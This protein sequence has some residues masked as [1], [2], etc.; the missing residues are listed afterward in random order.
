VTT[1]Y[2][3]ARLAGVSPSTV[4]RALNGHPR[5]SAAT[6]GRIRALADDFGY[7]TRATSHELL[8]AGNNLLGCVMHQNLGPGALEILQGMMD[9]AFHEGLVL[10]ILRTPNEPPAFIHQAVRTLIDLRIRAI[11]VAH[12]AAHALPDELLLRVRSSGTHLVAVNYG[13]LSAPIDQVKLDYATG[14]QLQAEYLHAL[15]HRV[16]AFFSCAAY[17]QVYVK[18]VTD[19]CRQRDITVALHRQVA[20]AESFDQAFAEMLSCPLRVTAVI[21]ENETLA[22]RA[23]AIARRHGLFIPDNLTI[24]G[25]TD[26]FRGYAFPELTTIDLHNREV[27][28]E[29]IKLM[30]RRLQ[31]GIPPGD[32]TPATIAIPPTLVVRQSAAPPA[33][34][35][36]IA[37]E[38]KSVGA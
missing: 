29:A 19:A 24:L 7:L 22:F 33:R 8:A 37:D 12:A 11:L 28:R 2:D 27:G 16:V 34:H 36:L 31:D 13:H 38:V 18:Q 4:S 35:Y 20:S 25:S 21:I 15:G 14:A 30:C 23:F 17:W 5:I 32:I 3:L 9:Q 26:A 10:S 1:I 6:R